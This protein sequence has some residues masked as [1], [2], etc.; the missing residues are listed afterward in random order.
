MHE[1][2]GPLWGGVDYCVVLIEHELLPEY[3][4]SLFAGVCVG[5]DAKTLVLQDLEHNLSGI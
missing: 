3:G 4:T 2:L 1:Y 5:I